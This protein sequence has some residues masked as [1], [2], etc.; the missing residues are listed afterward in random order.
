MIGWDTR[1]T[2]RNW[3]CNANDPQDLHCLHKKLPYFS[4]VG[5]FVIISLNWHALCIDMSSPSDQRFQL[6]LNEFFLVVFQK[7]P[8]NN[9]TKLIL[10][11]TLTELKLDGFK[12]VCNFATY[13]KGMLVNGWSPITK[14]VMSLLNHYSDS[15]W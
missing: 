7:Q 14:L 10:D 8:K 13:F 9:S 12:F 3:Q 1:T 6:F 2:Q 5:Q 11:I 4:Y 15:Q